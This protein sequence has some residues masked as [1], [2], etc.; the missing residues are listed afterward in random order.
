[1]NKKKSP[2]AA[3]HL[4]IISPFLT[5]FPIIKPSMENHT[6]IPPSPVTT[7]SRKP[8]IEYQAE[9]FGILH[10]VSILE[11]KFHAGLIPPPFY[12]KRMKQ[13]HLELGEVQQQL[14]QRGKPIS[15]ILNRLPV[16]ST[17]VMVKSTNF[18]PPT[19]LLLK[20]IT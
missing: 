15:E 10:T 4:Q 7:L 17:V 5:P 8:L 19:S 3:D 13:F 18:H 11:Q 9:V 2:A 12:F 20:P 14:S 1:M 16:A 6:W